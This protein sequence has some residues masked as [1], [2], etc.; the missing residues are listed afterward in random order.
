MKRLSANDAA[1]LSGDMQQVAAQLKDHLRDYRQFVR[2]YCR[3]A[4][5]VLDT[6]KFLQAGQ[7]ADALEVC[8]QTLGDVGATGY[9]ND[10]DTPEWC[11]NFL[12]ED[13]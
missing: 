10:Y 11:R 6:V 8:L 2:N 1:V 5:A 7:H 4:S 12:K 13:N 3:L 9:E